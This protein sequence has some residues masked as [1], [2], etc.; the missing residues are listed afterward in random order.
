MKRKNYSK[1]NPTERNAWHHNRMPNLLM[2][3]KA[4]SVIEKR[5]QKALQLREQHFTQLSSTNNFFKTLLSK[6]KEVTVYTTKGTRTYQL[7]TNGLYEKETKSFVVVAIDP[8]GRAILFRAKP[9]LSKKVDPN[10]WIPVNG[11]TKE[12]EASLYK[13]GIS[14]HKE[15]DSLTFHLEKETSAIT[16]HPSTLQE[17]ASIRQNL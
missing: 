4:K 14:F 13:I 8:W 15:L 1:M 5:L 9:N 17:L 2:V 16:F 11:I 10:T 6:R 12:G 3:N 7:L